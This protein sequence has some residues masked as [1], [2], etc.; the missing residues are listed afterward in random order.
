M[1]TIAKYIENTLRMDNTVNVGDKE[2]IVSAVT[3]AGLLVSGIDDVKYADNKISAATKIL[4]GGYMVYR[5]VTGYCPL[6]KAIGLDTV[7]IPDY[8]EISETMYVTRPVE[9]VYQAWRQLENLPRFMKH[10]AEVDQIT[11]KR[12]HWEA[13]I[14]GGIGKISWEAE[15]TFEKENEVLL[16][17]SLPG[18]TINNSGE[19]FF[20]DN[21][22]GTTSLKATIVYHP[23]AGEAGKTIAKV[24]NN[25]FGNMIR[26]DLRGFKK[27]IEANRTEKITY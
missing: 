25:L 27:M 23:P 20:K 17:T 6:R 10:L 12:S 9:E 11:P 22:D 24:L 15:I 21:G 18:S 5:A 13:K 26:E 14:P 8:L 2:R 7:H 1:T 19:V 16:W 3:G 4:A